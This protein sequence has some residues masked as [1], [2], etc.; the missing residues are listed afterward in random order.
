MK[1]SDMNVF[2]VEDDKFYAEIIR[3][4]LINEGFTN[5][6]LFESGKDFLNYEG[7]SPHIVVLD[8][9]L[10]QMSGIHILKVIKSKNALTQ[11]IFLS[12]QED[13]SVVVDALKYGAYDYIEKVDPRAM[14]R[15][16]V[17][18]D[19]AIKNRIKLRRN[20]RIESLK[21]W[22]LIK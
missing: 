20:N 15:L 1:S 12:A 19:K 21:G 9:M 4:T 6:R 5:I 3:N 14:K 22:F 2:L 11:V 8:H 17:M 10:G 16:I 18:I 13:M 7:D